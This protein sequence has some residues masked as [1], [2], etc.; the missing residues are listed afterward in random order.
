[1]SLTLEE[2]RRVRFRMARRGTTGYDVA[3]VDN[4]IDKVEE[5]FGAF[6]NERDLLRREAESAGSASA[7]ATTAVAAPDQAALSA[8]DDEIASLRAEV[9]R[10]NGV[11]AA[12]PSEDA[13][14]QQPMGDSSGHIAELEA[15]NEQLRSE[16]GRVRG[17]LD[18][19]R[20]ARVNE[21]VGHAETITVTTR[22]EASPAVIR[23]V[24]LAT[25]QAEQVVSEAEAEASRKLDDAKQQAFE[26]TTDART[27]ADRIESEA[28]VNAE[29]VTREAQQRA[30]HVNT[31]AEQRRAELFTD[32]EREQG[33]LTTKVGALRD[34][35]SR[36]R[37]NL[38]GYVSRHLGALDND[39]PEPEDAD[40]VAP[41][42]ESRTPR[43]DALAQGNNE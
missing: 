9:D 22:E 14:P 41:R 26:I 6:E 35:E 28:R 18:E 2:V 21:V 33:E 27:K 8:K 36:Y 12:A 19:L 31:E 43:L 20:T 13:A 23:L 1:M 15:Q 3:D 30:D 42:S 29:Q 5:S 24:Q 40:E 25:E 10:L 39:L 34:F 17:E 32:L 38:R 11:L 16:L 4:F 37:E 7:P